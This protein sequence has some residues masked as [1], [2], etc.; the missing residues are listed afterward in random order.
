[1]F[2]VCGLVPIF[3]VSRYSES[4]VSGT[5]ETA[6]ISPLADEAVEFPEVL[7]AVADG[8]ELFEAEPDDELF[9]PDEP[10]DARADVAA[11]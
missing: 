3:T 7:V 10:D 1:M 6:P 2:I 5:A 9:E 11:G 8:L 4:S